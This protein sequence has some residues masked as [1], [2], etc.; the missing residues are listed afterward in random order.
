MESYQSPSIQLVGGSVGSAKALSL[1]KMGYAVLAVAGAAI[2]AGAVAAVV[3]G[4][5][6]VWCDP[7]W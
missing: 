3:Y 2:V 7:Y 4:A 6:W 1:I 5:A